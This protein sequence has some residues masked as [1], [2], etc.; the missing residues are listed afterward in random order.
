MM[1]RSYQRITKKII[2]HRFKTLSASLRYIKYPP[3]RI[4]PLLDMKGIA[5][6]GADARI[7]MMDI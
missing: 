6:K 2:I 5:V 4:A 1:S 7:S 3:S